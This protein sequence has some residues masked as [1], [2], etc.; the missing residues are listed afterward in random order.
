M[1][2]YKNLLPPDLKNILNKYEDFNNRHH[3]EIIKC[4]KCIDPK[5]IYNPDTKKCIN[6]TSKN[7]ENLIE[8]IIFCDK[9]FKQKLNKDD[10]SILNNLLNIPINYNGYTIRDLLPIGPIP[11][12]KKILAIV[13]FIIS[14]LMMQIK[15]V[16]NI[17]INLIEHL[18]SLY[19]SNFILIKLKNFIIQKPIFTA[20]YNF[21]NGSIKFSY[22]IIEYFFGQKKSDV[23]LIQE[24][25]NR[26]IDVYFVPKH[27]DYKEIHIPVFNL[28]DHNITNIIEDLLK[29]NKILMNDGKNLYLNLA[30]LG[31]NS[32]DLYN[33]KTKFSIID[34]G[35]TLVIKLI[36]DGDIFH[37]KYVIFNKKGREYILTYNNKFNTQTRY[38][39]KLLKQLYEL[40]Q[41][42]K[43]ENEK[44]QNLLE[45]Q[46]LEIQNKRKIISELKKNKKSF[47]KYNIE[48][49]NLQKFEFKSNDNEKIY[50]KH[51]EANYY[52]FLKKDGLLD[53]VK[54]RINNIKSQNVNSEYT[55]FTKWLDMINKNI[56]NKIY[57]KLY[58][59]DLN[60][61]VLYEKKIIENIV[62]K[63]SS[64]KIKETLDLAQK[65]LSQKRKD[66]I[67]NKNDQTSMQIVQQTINNT[68]AIFHGSI[69]QSI[70]ALTTT[71][72]QA[73]QKNT[74]KSLEQNLLKN[75]E[76]YDLIKPKKSSSSSKK[77]LLTITSPLKT[78]EEKIFNDYKEKHKNV[79]LSEFK[80]L[81]RNPNKKYY[82]PTKSFI[83]NELF[84]NI[85]NRKKS[86]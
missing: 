53:K 10:T 73:E 70:K 16:N 51:T 54:D 3:K 57:E 62:R 63:K 77:S 39:D 86:V 29:D 24:S 58:E 40:K 69:D 38:K 59:K 1:S 68:G 5:K 74:P 14:T 46:N 50:L 65:Q 32:N 37:D 45:I 41:K 6:R 18:L 80:K 56:N 76:Q 83:D 13:L 17:T 84:R 48:I 61:I 47:S 72:L 30:K 26:N 44:I 31:L 8:N 33:E 78:S 9:Y 79:T 36:A 20:I 71:G 43:K 35:D 12:T 49:I 19:P 22:I 64:E 85:P 55:F 23:D 11:H 34:N 81:V 52:Q 42:I 67:F 25:I 75:L 2:I 7:A 15:S 4:E 60:S 28:K 27:K 21:F 66:E 82:I